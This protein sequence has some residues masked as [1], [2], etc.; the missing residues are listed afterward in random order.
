MNLVTSQI[1]ENLF[2]AF[3]KA[4]TSYPGTN[5]NTLQNLE[6]NK[7]AYEQHQ[8]NSSIN[9]S[10]TGGLNSGQAQQD[11][12][13]ETMA[14]IP[15]LDSLNYNTGRSTPTYTSK[16][17]DDLHQLIGKDLPNTRPANSEI[18]EKQTIGMAGPATDATNKMAMTGQMHSSTVTHHNIRLDQINSPVMNGNEVVFAHASDEYAFF[19]KQSIIDASKHS[20][21]SSFPRQHPQPKKIPQIRND[22]PIVPPPDNVRNNLGPPPPRP[23]KFN[24]VNVKMH[25]KCQENKKIDAVLQGNPS[26]PLTRDSQSSER[27]PKCSSTPAIHRHTTVVSASEGTDRSA[28]SSL[29]GGSSSR[30]S[31]SDDNSDTASDEGQGQGLSLEHRKKRKVFDVEGSAAPSKFGKKNGDELFIS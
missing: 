1:H 5:T 15:T 31:G 9:L 18:K 26:L 28:E 19:A 14:M 21:Y 24:K 16:S 4:Q 17:F 20:A 13:N 12:I 25:S 8:S 3:K 22:T 23:M 11:W 2:S 10:P 30:S 29:I 6:P 27:V 7:N